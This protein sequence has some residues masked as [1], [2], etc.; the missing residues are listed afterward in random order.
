VNTRLVDATE[1]LLPAPL[2]AYAITFTA[3]LWQR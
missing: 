2:L 1:L 3:P